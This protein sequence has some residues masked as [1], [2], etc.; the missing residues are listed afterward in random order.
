MA[1]PASLSLLLPVLLPLLPQLLPA[2]DHWIALKSGPFEVFSNVGERPAREKLMYLEQ[3]RETLRVITG[4][5]EM[6]MVWPVHVIIFKNAAEIP[7]APKQFT[8]GRDARM[9]AIPEAGGFSTDDLK[10]LARLLLYENTNRLPPQME[11]GMIE[12]VS[13]VQIDGPRITLGAPGSG[14]R[15]FAGLGS[16]APGDGE[17]GIRRPLQRHDF[18]SGTK[19]RFR[20]RLPQ[21]LRE[22]R[23]ANS[24]AGR[25]VSQGGELRAP[26]RFPDAR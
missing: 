25:R 17:S 2:E 8:L 19:R 11:K 20:S 13:T 24:T 12:L 18:E 22:D 9:A 10:E 3:F 14:S 15:T 26:L 1:V 7:A 5:Q 6:R 23:R 16:D 21:R 4:K